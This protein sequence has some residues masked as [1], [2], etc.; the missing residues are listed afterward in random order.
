MK[1]QNQ[2]R[3]Q[4]GDR[5]DTYKK[6]GERR[7]I[8]ILKHNRNQSAKN[9]LSQWNLSLPKNGQIS[10]T[11][12]RLIIRKYGFQGRSPA[13]KFALS[14]SMRKCRQQWSKERRLRSEEQWKNRFIF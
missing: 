10:L 2:S 3:V 8:R 14:C 11:T 1:N 5:K 4:V 13:K 9:S 12:A 6:A 7:L